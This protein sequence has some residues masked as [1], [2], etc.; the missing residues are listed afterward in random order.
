VRLVRITIEYDMDDTEKPLK[1]EL[2]DWIKGSITV[3]D[4]F[5]D[6]SQWATPTTVVGHWDTTD[7][8]RINELDSQGEVK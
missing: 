8:I 5:D 1:E 4:L 2:N 7:T 3:Q 6:R